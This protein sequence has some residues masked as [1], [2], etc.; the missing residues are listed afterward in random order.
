MGHENAWVWQQTTPSSKTRITLTL[1]S[2]LNLR[3]VRGAYISN[4]SRPVWYLH[5]FPLSFSKSYVH[6]VDRQWAVDSCQ[7]RGFQSSVVNWHASL[8]TVPQL[9]FYPTQPLC[10]VLWKID[11]FHCLCLVTCLVTALEGDYPN[12]WPQYPLNDVMGA[13]SRDSLWREIRR[14]L[15]LCVKTITISWSRVQSVWGTRERAMYKRSKPLSK[16]K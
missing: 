3:G 15:F 12:V 10:A 1:M 14:F 7:F 16:Q 13:S 11:S 5:A 6:A 2:R 9:W 8:N 4:S